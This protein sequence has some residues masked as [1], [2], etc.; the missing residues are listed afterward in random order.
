M[1]VLLARHSQLQM[2]SLKVR[3]IP[4]A[5][6]ARRSQET[7]MRGAQVNCFARGHHTG[8][9]YLPLPSVH[10]LYPVGIIA[11]AGP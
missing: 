11:A 5:L 9:D 8:C 2:V 3:F 6:S 7:Q 4:K 10:Q 1:E